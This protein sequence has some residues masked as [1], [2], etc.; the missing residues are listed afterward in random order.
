MAK[1]RKH[2]QGEALVS[3]F[4]AEQQIDISERAV[5]ETTRDT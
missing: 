3:P 4:L 2:I 5:G 1:R